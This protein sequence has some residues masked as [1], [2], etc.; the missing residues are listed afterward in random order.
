MKTLPPDHDWQATLEEL[1]AR[2]L[3]LSEGKV[4]RYI[5]ELAKALPTWFGIAVAT[6]DGRVFEVGDTRQG[7]TLQ[8][9][10][11][12]FSYGLALEDQGRA[13][14]LERVGVEPTGE[15][16]NSIIRLDSSTQRPHNPMV[17]AG[18][19]AVASMIDGPDASTRL[20]RVLDMF[21]RYVGH[22]VG[23]DMPVFVSERATGHRNRAIAHLMLNYGMLEGDVEDTLDLYFQLCSVRADCRDLALLAGTLANGGVNPLTHVRALD[24]AY[25]RDLLSVMFTSGLYDYAGQWAYTVG[26]P[27]KSGVAGGLLAVVPGQL[28]VGIYSPP[29][30]EH[31]NS[32][33]ALR[34]CEDLSRE[35]G[36]HVFDS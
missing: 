26:V 16:F 32:L 1:H 6:V 19:I 27:A 21:E 12:P 31:G 34:V 20:N 17:N 23:V 28:G 18:A 8:S 14:V 3:G 22:E 24:P 4:A 10:A 25:L 13:E 9:V 7:F 35:L 36:L 5:P 15:V 11:K 33:R 29:L 2:Y 30:D